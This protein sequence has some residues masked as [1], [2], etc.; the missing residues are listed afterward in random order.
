MTDTCLKK[1]GD[2]FIDNIGHTFLDHSNEWKWVLKVFQFNHHCYNWLM[3]F[4][5]ICY[6]TRWSYLC[7]T[8]DIYQQA[9]NLKLYV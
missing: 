2:W 5:S 6:K 8:L 1:L 4:I 7:K 3:P 9:Y